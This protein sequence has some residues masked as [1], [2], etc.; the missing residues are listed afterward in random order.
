MAN[1]M[2]RPCWDGAPIKGGELWILR[3]VRGRTAHV[4]VCEL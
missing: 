2:Q 1:V 4:A 3:K